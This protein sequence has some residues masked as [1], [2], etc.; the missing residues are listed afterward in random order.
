MQLEDPGIDFHK[1][2]EFV[3]YAVRELISGDRC[4][5]GFV[6]GRDS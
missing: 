1:E 6:S 5:G 2:G 3:M 4:E